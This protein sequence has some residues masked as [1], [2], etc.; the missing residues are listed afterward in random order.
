MCIQ[1]LD[2]YRSA[3]ATDHFVVH[4]HARVLV[5]ALRAVVLPVT[6]IV[7]RDARPPGVQRLREIGR[8]ALSVALVMALA[9][10]CKMVGSLNRLHFFAQFQ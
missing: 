6:E 7:V 2:A 3:F 4:A 9:R 5:F 10:H 8:R 1:P